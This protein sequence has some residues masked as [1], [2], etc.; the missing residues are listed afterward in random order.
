MDGLRT[1]N[2]FDNVRTCRQWMQRTLNALDHA[3]HYGWAVDAH[4]DYCA[5]TPH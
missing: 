4:Q 5:L 1:H 3:R 2:A